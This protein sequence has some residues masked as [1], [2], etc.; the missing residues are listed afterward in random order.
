[1]N[2]R[3]AASLINDPTM[4]SEYEYFKSLK[5]K[6][7]KIV[8]CAE[9]YFGKTL[10]IIPKNSDTYKFTW[11]S[12]KHWFD[13]EYTHHNRIQTG[14]YTKSELIEKMTDTLYNETEWQLF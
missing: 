12:S 1:M 4:K 7:K 13:C 5:I 3:K 10:L 14:Y 6:A 8:D 11:N 2:L 9:C